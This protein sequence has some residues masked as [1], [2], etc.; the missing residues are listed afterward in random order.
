MAYTYQPFP[1]MMYL[2]GQQVIVQHAGEERAR[3]RDGWGPTPDWTLEMAVEA[4]SQPALP[5]TIPPVQM[6]PV[7]SVPV[8]DD[9][10]KTMATTL[11]SRPR[12]RPRK[13]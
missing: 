1:R 2:D 7:S 4:V 6:A 13:S 11:G 3:T 10:Q 8:V 12:G 9:R 5:V